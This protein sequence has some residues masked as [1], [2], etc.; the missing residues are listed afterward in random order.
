MNKKLLLEYQKIFFQKLSEKTGLTLDFTKNKKVLDVGCGNGDDCNFFA[1]YAGKVVGVDCKQSPK[2]KV[3]KRNNLRFS[4]GNA[5]KLAFPNSC[6][7]IVFSKDVLHHTK[8]PMLAIKEMKRVVKKKG[9]V[10]IIEGNRYNPL[11]YLHMT[12]IQGHEHIPQKRFKKYVLE[13]FPKAGFFH[14]ESHYF[15]FWGKNAMKF[16]LSVGEI[17]ERF[18]FLERFLSYN[19]ALVKNTKS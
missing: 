12:I 15:P 16:F 5:E 4:K 13:V 8:N 19:L 1:R 10:I 3:L 2:W 18:P 9:T 11:S 6:F 17:F 14:F 7:D